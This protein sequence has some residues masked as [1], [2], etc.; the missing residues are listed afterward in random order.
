[1]KLTEGIIPLNYNFN[2]QSQGT[3]GQ[4]N[5]EYEPYLIKIHADRIL[6]ELDIKIE[7]LIRGNMIQ[8]LSEQTILIL[9]NSIENKVNEFLNQSTYVLSKNYQLL[10]PSYDVLEQKMK[11]F[12]TQC[13]KDNLTKSSYVAYNL[14]KRIIIPNPCG[15][16][17]L[18]IGWVNVR[19]NVSI[20]NQ[21]I[22][23][24]FE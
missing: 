13:E 22:D 24:I 12:N 10:M 18:V 11:E 3:R 19:S 17:N 21:N 5:Q 9:E 8:N 4:Q 7:N 16:S 23:M 6:K 15:I 2:K 1:M 14:D 20:N